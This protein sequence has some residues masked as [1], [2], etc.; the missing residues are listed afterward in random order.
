M[1]RRQEEERDA[2]GGKPGKLHVKEVRVEPRMKTV[3]E[4]REHCFGKKWWSTL[5]WCIRNVCYAPHC[6][7][8]RSLRSSKTAVMEWRS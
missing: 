7:T 2:R 4:A 6:D 5:V 1:D 3:V 8:R